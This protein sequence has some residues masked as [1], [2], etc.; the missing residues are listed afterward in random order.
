M[1]VRNIVVMAISLLFFILLY[2]G[3][4]IGITYLLGEFEEFVVSPFRIELSLRTPT[5]ERIG[6][7]WGI[8]FGAP[9][10]ITIILGYVML[11]QREKLAKMKPFRQHVSYWVTIMLLLIHPLILSTGAKS[12]GGQ[13]I[14]LAVALGIKP[15]LIQLIAIIIFLVNRELIA[16]KLFDAYKVEIKSF[17]WLPIFPRNHKR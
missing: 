1:S 8:L 12:V 4:C 6:V 3:L 16:Q 14:R 13:S 11:A 17:L 10:L 7:K 15:Y 9:V 2:Q 5:Y